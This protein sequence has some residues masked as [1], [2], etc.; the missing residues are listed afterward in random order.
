MGEDNEKSTWR[1]ASALFFFFFY[2]N[3]NAV[4]KV[5][6]R[7]MLTEE[8]DQTSVQLIGKTIVDEYIVVS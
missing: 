8:V 1:K 3:V 5:L 4:T 2:Q 6:K 7:T